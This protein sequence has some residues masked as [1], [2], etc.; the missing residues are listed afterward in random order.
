MKGRLAL[1]FAEA[2]VMGCGVV[3]V[4]S[5]EHSDSDSDSD[6]DSA[7]VATGAEVRVIWDAE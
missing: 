1:V 5:D 7:A 3:M 4:I 2:V 6:S